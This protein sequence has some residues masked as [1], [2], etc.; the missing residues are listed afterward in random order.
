MWLINVDLREHG[1]ARMVGGREVIR[2]DSVVLLP[3]HA[4]T[5]VNR[6]EGAAGDGVASADVSV[7]SAGFRLCKGKAAI[8]A[9]DIGKLEETAVVGDGHTTVAAARSFEGAGKRVLVLK[10]P[11]EGDGT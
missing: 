1:D 11:E 9:G 8:M 5:T 2:G 10:E 3:T 7:A 6:E 4:V